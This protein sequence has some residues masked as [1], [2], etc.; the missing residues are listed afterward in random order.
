MEKGRIWRPDLCPDDLAVDEAALL[1]RLG[2]P[3]AKCVSDQ[4]RRVLDQIGEPLR[5]SCRPKAVARFLELVEIESPKRGF[6]VPGGFVFSTRLVSGA[7]FPAKLWAAFALT[8]GEPTLDL[9]G[10]KGGDLLRDYCA[11][12]VASVLAEGLA[13]KVHE[14][15][16]ALMEESGLVSGFRYSPGYC[17]WPVTDNRELL[18]LAD[19]ESIGI[20][21]TPGGMMSPRKSISAIVAFG[22]PDSTIREPACRR[23]EKRC[24][25]FRK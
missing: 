16:S 12:A 23:C 9:P 3:D 21:L 18:A 15:L 25:H 5:R 1:F 22:E 13:Q 19:A 7:L 8:I 10:E 24:P 17:D 6:S 20:T 14:R 11:D 2:Y 4:V